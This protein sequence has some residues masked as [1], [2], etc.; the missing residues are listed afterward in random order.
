MT[1]TVRRAKIDKQPDDDYVRA[2][3][4]SK[5]ECNFIN[6]FCLDV[7]ISF[8]LVLYVAIICRGGKM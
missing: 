6:C 7:V 4:A 8:T 3:D 2:F 5:Q 1:V